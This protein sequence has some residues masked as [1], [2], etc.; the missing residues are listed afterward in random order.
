MHKLPDNNIEEH[1]FCTPGQIREIM[2][3]AQQAQCASQSTSTIVFLK[4]QQSHF[5]NK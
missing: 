1:H 2:R 5:V 3:P 4:I